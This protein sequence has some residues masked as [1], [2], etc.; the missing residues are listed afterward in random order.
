MREPQDQGLTITLPTLQNEQALLGDSERA[1]SYQQTQDNLAGQLSARSQRIYTGDVE[2]F[3]WWL[4]ASLAGESPGRYKDHAREAQPCSPA[5]AAMLLA[6]LTRDQVIAYRAYL[7]TKDPTDA[8]G[9]RRLYAKT[10]AV[11][12]L[13]VVRR[14][15][16]EA[17]FK[18]L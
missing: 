18:G 14:L 16:A 12:R 8:E 17:V 4:R 13:T 5:E 2:A 11:R 6:Q 9:N 3:L 10:T 1:A 15:C 7:D